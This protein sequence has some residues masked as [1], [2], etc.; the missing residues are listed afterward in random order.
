MIE[1]VVVYHPRMDELKDEYENRKRA[2]EQAGD[3]LAEESRLHELGLDYPYHVMH[4]L[5][6]ESNGWAPDVLH[7]HGLRTTTRLYEQEN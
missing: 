7:T 4:T 5:Y 3:M 2:G 6:Y 1:G